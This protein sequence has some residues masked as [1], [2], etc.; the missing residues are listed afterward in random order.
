MSSIYSLSLFIFV[1]DPPELEAMRCV[2]AKWC[3]PTSI[4]PIKL[5]DDTGSAGGRPGS[6][7]VINSMDMI[8]VTAGHEAP[9]E[10]FYELMSNRFFIDPTQLPAE[11]MQA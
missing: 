3:N 6:I 10:T 4:S 8:C 2:P 7:W 11:A 5:W 1:E 9:K